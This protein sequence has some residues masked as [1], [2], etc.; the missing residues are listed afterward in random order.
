MSKIEAIYKVEVKD[1]KGEIVYSVE[2]P[3]HSFT[4]QFLQIL[5]SQLYPSTGVSPV[6][7]IDG[8]G[9][10]IIEHAEN[11]DLEGG[12]G[13]TTKGILVGTGTTTPTNIDFVM[14]TLIANGAG[15]GQLNYAG[16]TQVATAVVGANVDFTLIRTMT[17][18][19]GGTINVTEIGIYMEG[20]VS[21]VGTD[22][23]LILHEVIS[24][25]AVANGQTITVTILFRTTV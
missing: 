19:S 23:N 17:N 24:S 9:N 2:K 3:C 10:T 7:D 11:M 12:A 20:Y 4:L 21:G 18:A 1:K 6:K 14:E 15:A 25:V 8:T 16:M 13:D 22:D 5:A